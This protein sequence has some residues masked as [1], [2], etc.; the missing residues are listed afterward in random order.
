PEGMRVARGKYHQ[1]GLILQAS[2]HTS[3]R[4][5]NK[6]VYTRMSPSVPFMCALFCFFAL[7]SYTPSTPSF[8]LASAKIPQ[9]N[10]YLFDR[11][12]FNE[13]FSIT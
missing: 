6:N 12:I 1:Q 4:R 8:S 7:K 9:K 5:P 13:I 3:L 10:K 2:S 11:S